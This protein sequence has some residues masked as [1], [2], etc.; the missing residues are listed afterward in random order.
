MSEKGD[1]FVRFVIAESGSHRKIAKKKLFAVEERS[2]VRRRREGNEGHE[3]R[4]VGDVD[5]FVCVEGEGTLVIAVGVLVGE[6]HVTGAY[7]GENWQ[8]KRRGAGLK[9][10]CTEGKLVRSV[11]TCEKKTGC[12]GEE[13]PAASL[14]VLDTRTISGKG[15]AAQ[16]AAVR[17]FRK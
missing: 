16:Q 10:F 5:G 14:M 13:K 17:Q 3:A 11:C 12:R 6:G 8:W 2:G 4:A 7:A 15:R 1:E 9:P